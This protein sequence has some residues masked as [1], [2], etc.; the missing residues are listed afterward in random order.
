M[1]VS[2]RDDVGIGLGGRQVDV[3]GLTPCLGNAHQIGQVQIRV[4][5][6]HD[7]DALGEQGVAGALGH[8]AYDGYDQMLLLAP[9]RLDFAQAAKHALLGVVADGARVDEYRVGGADVVGHGVALHVEH[10][11]HHLAVGGVHL[12]SVG[13]D[14]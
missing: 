12:A 2:L 13:L 3:D 1:P 9:Q 14:E 11:G 6:G 5:P 4:G 10:G 7:V 8:A